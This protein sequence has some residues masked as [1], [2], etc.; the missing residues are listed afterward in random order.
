MSLR[1][2]SYSV[3]TLLFLMTFL[4]RLSMVTWTDITYLRR[5]WS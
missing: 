3:R 5:I 2:E 4:R 1:K